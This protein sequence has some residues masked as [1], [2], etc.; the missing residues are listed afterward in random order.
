MEVR[1]QGHLRQPGRRGQAEEVIVTRSG[2][3][4]QGVGIGLRAPHYGAFLDGDPAVPWLE[5]HSE[6]YFGDGGFDLHVLDTVRQRY[7]VSL[8]GVGM[9]LGSVDGLSDR[10]VEHLARLVERVEPALVSEH[11]CWGRSGDRHFNDLLPMPYTRE[12]LALMVERVDALQNRLSRRI[13]IENVSSYLA[14]AHDD[15]SEVEFLV[16]LAQ[17]SG[18]GLL[19]DINNLYVNAVNHGFDARTALATIPAGVVGEIHLAGHS[20]A[21]DVLID[22]HGSRV[23][24]PVRQL[25][26]SAI[27]RFGAVPTLIEWDTAIPP[28][29]VL[30]DEA[31]RAATLRDAPA[32]A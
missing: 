6:N 14:Y 20:K 18:C 13:L 32:D 31:V 1:R 22:D 9:A 5:V 21:D 8:H 17:R 7:P 12:A 4:L 29:D 27:D 15:C 2:T 10:H 3:A 16:E 19:L 26:R 28:L 30:L 25:Y 23:G 24:E 11:V